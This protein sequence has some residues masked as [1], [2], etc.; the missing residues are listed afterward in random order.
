MDNIVYKNRE[1]LKNLGISDFINYC[2]CV[3]ANLKKPSD[4]A[5]K[6]IAL[7]V[8]VIVKAEEDRRIMFALKT[9]HDKYQILGFRFDV[10]LWVTICD[11][12]W[13]EKDVLVSMIALNESGDKYTIY[14]SCG[15][16]IPFS[17]IISHGVVVDKLYIIMGKWF[18][19]NEAVIKTMN[20]Y[21]TN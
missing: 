10:P 2:N 13:V 12:N 7:D 19:V 11:D 18:R 15:Y 21:L 14:D 16:T 9:F 5:D 1:E 17:F 8:S 4:D 3:N 6:R 20:N